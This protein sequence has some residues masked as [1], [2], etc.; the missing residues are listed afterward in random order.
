M[1]IIIRTIQLVGSGLTL[2]ILADIIVSLALSPWHP[3]RRTLDA[4]VNPL[5]APIRRVLPPVG[6]LDFSP[7]VLVILIQVAQTVLVI[8]VRSL[9]S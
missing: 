4:W 1:D 3:L 2:L 8:L 9:G 5:L 6:M 7:M